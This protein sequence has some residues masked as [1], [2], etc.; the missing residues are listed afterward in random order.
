MDLIELLEIGGSGD[1]AGRRPDTRQNGL[2]GII[3]ARLRLCGGMR[4]RGLSSGWLASLPA[5]ARNN[6]AAALSPA[7]A[8]ALLYDWPFWARSTQLPPQ[9]NWRVWLLSAGRGFVRP[10]RAPS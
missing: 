4:L 10:E 7:E 3:E 6:L 2:S 1:G 5:P 8:R 9:G